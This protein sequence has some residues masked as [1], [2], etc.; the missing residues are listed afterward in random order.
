MGELLTV[1]SG[2]IWWQIPRPGDRAEGAYKRA[3]P[4][5]GRDHIDGMRR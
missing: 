3:M 2:G 4:Y 1:F 5:R